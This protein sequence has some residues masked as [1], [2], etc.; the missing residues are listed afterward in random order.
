MY[1]RYAETH[2]IPV[3][4]TR[5]LRE[6][7]VADVEK[8]LTDK[9]AVLSTRSL[10]IIHSI[11]S[12]AVRKAQVR[13]KIRRNIVL[14]CEVPEGRAGRQSKS[15]TLMQAEALLRAAE[16]GPPRMGAYIIVSLLTSAHTEEMRALRWH[17]V[18]QTGQP[19]GSRLIPLLCRITTG[20][21]ALF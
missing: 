14:L 21:C 20:R 15:L 17:D 4:R 7:T 11:L 3:L 1:R 18:D 12:R 13:D 2:I 8:L 16:Q 9:S 5:K 19:D 10:R 6:L